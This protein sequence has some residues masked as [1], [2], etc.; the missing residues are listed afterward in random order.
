MADLDP[1][2]LDAVQGGFAPQ[3]LPDGSGGLGAP[4]TMDFSLPQS[5]S[6][7]VQNGFAPSS[8]PVA[9]PDQQPTADFSLPS[10]VAS[11]VQNGFAPPAP[12]PVA[13]P[14]SRALSGIAAPSAD[15]GA[16][17][18]GNVAQAPPEIEMPAMS[19]TTGKPATPAELRAAKAY[20]ASPEGIAQRAEGEQ[21][22]GVNEERGALQDAT[23]AEV[24]QNDAKAAALT[25][26]AER[27]ADQK[28]TDDAKKAAYEADVNKYTAQYAQQIKDAANFKVNTDRHISNVGLIA[29]ALTGIGN[30][31]D[32]YHGPNAALEIL[33][34]GIDK[35]IADEWAQKKAL[36]DQ[37]DQTKSLLGVAR[38]NF[39]D[40]RQEQQMQRAAEREK[41]ADDLQLVAA[42]TAN[43]AVK[44][45]AEAAAA[46][47]TQKSAAITMSEAQRKAQAVKDAQ[48]AADRRAQIG[49]H[50]ATLNF[51]KQKWQDQYALQVAQLQA[52]GRGEEAKR[53]EEA[54]KNGLNVVS[55]VNKDGTPTYVPLKQQDGSQFQVPEKQQ[56]K[57]HDAYV[58]TGIVIDAVDKLTKARSNFDTAEQF[59]NFITTTE[60]GR[61]LI[62]QYARA[63]VGTHQAIG[64]TR[65][66]GEV[67]KL[68]EEMLT[69]G[70]D[71]KSIKAIIPSL[72]TARRDAI[73]S[74][75]IN[76][77]HRANYTGRDLSEKDFPNPANMP[78]T[79]DDAIDKLGKQANARDPAEKHDAGVLFG[80]GATQSNVSKQA[81]DAQRLQAIQEIE[82][83]AEGAP[84][85]AQTRSVATLKDIAD[86]GPTEAVRSAAREALDRVNIASGIQYHDE[87]ASTR[88]AAVSRI[89]PDEV[90]G[91][92]KK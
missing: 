63:V 72:Q 20:E 11:A 4:A 16:P 36:G 77:H 54:A 35:R 32:H 73:D 50:Y 40:A 3:A 60:E 10:S 5:V 87:G 26:A 27:A 47:L 61:G 39:D 23:A 80:G 85:A 1:S 44:A 84:G 83:Q 79:P 75:N 53:I 38:S 69:G 6:Q 9:L 70:A 90:I 74:F 81:G 8:A 13:S 71:P 14:T 2:V 42:Q 7:A 62:Q 21:R 46:Q 82:K 64:V 30:A 45:R 33:E 43:P 92:K 52:Q 17:S 68:S 59:E 41:L 88:S 37:A 34:R 58:G 76:L 15:N 25:A 78:P 18:L 29:I 12:T 22:Q 86:K 56:E 66:S 51:E 48:E 65:F 67:V 31:L 89:Q 19:A 49:A 91:G 55:G 28:K 24:A 57:I